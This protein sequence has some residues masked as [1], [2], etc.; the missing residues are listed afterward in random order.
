MPGRWHGAVRGGAAGRYGSWVSIPRG[1]TLAGR[2]ASLGFADADQAERLIT[3]E[4]ALDVKGADGDLIE[5]LAAAADPDAALAGLA[6]LAL[7]AGLLAALRAEPGFRTRLTAVL[8]ASTALADHLA[9]HSGDWRELS[10]PEAVSEPTAGELRARRRIRPGCPARSGPAT[11]RPPACEW[12]FA[13]AC[14]G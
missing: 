8:G 12:R 1:T 4:L 2:L 14:C 13:A 11:T 7:D 10:G 3:G 5:A 6:R 9:R